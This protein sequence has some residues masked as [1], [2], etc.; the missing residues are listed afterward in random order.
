MVASRD[1]EVRQSVRVL[2]LQNKDLWIR[3]TDLSLHFYFLV[4]IR[5][6]LLEGHLRIWKSGMKP[7]R[8][9]KKKRGQIKHTGIRLDSRI[10]TSNEMLYIDFLGK[11]IH[12]DENNV[13]LSR[14]TTVHQ[15]GHLPFWLWHVRQLSLV[16]VSQA[17]HFVLPF[18]E[19]LSMTLPHG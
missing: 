18:C 7:R 11:V 12:G 13:C 2:E 9:L 8:R 15:Y 1:Y 3:P 17:R 14:T 6:L 19:P 10:S 5:E 4:T 16:V